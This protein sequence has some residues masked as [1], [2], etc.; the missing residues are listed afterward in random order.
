MCYAMK[1]LE[2]TQENLTLRDD[3]RKIKEQL[4]QVAA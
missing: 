1:G 4:N 2:Y 3:L